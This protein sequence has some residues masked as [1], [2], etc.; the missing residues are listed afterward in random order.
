M[1]EAGQGNGDAAEVAW[2]ERE[3]EL[4]RVKAEIAKQTLTIDSEGAK[5]YEERWQAIHN[6]PEAEENRRRFEKE[7]ARKLKRK[8]EEQMEVKWRIVAGELGGSWRKRGE[9]FRWHTMSCMEVLRL[10]RFTREDKALVAAVQGTV[11][12]VEDSRD[13]LRNEI[14][15]MAGDFG[16]A[17]AAIER[18]RT[19]SYDQI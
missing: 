11:H 12:V 15:Y 1:Q 14:M 5:Q 7:Y 3:T 4:A 19:G 16:S 2:V 10:M 9:D 13:T 17:V 6:P 8:Q 18:S